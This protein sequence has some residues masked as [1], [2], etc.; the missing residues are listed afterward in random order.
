MSETKNSVLDQYGAQRFEKQQ[1][2]TTG[3][4]GVKATSLYIFYWL[5]QTSAEMRPLTRQCRKQRNSCHLMTCAYPWDSG[6]ALIPR[7][8]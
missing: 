3:V 8:L 1:F 7:L 6:D 5:T 2:G 4:E